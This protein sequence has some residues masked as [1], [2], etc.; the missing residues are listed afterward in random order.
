MLSDA[1]A[2][3]ALLFG[4]LNGSRLQPPD[5][6][7]LR[8]GWLR[9][10][11]AMRRTLRQ[12]RYEYVATAVLNYPISVLELGVTA[13]RGADVGGGAVKSGKG[14][15]KALLPWQVDP[16]AILKGLSG[17][18]QAGMAMGRQMHAAAAYAPVFAAMATT[19]MGG[20]FIATPPPV[21]LLKWYP[22]QNKQAARN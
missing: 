17:L 19:A 8:A 4:G 5:L 2:I 1:A 10:V 3:V 22:I 15:L 7:G 18:A 21:Y 14:L 11:K 20:K 16:V 12:P 13:L 9:E 6:E